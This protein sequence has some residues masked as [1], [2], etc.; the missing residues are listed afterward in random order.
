[1]YVTEAEKNALEAL[2]TLNGENFEKVDERFNAA[3]YGMGEATEKLDEISKQVE[4]YSTKITDL[5]DKLSTLNTEKETIEGNYAV[6]NEKVSELE[7]EVNSLKDYKAAVEKEKKLAVINTYSSVLNDD[8][9]EDFTNRIDEYADEISLDKDMAYVLKKSNFQFFNQAPEY[10]P[11]AP[12]A[13]EEGSLREL[14]SQ[15]K[16]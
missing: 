9:I 16:K 11:A 8:I 3:I 15:Y 4:E 5:E 7:K 13:T 1:M 12:T 10:I 14:L 2:R 6:A